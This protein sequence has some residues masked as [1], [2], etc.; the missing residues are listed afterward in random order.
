MLGEVRHGN[1]IQTLLNGN[2]EM[3]VE[4]VIVV[5]KVMDLLDGEHLEHLQGK[6]VFLAV[7]KIYLVE[8]SILL[9]S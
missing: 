3:V 4:A 5:G 8:A 2:F 7:E 9:C 6:N 1:V